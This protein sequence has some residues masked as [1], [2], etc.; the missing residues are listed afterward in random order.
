MRKL[1]LYTKAGGKGKRGTCEREQR[2][3]S[4]SSAEPSPDTHTKQLPPHPSA[5]NRR[6]SEEKD[7]FCKCDNIL[8]GGGQVVALILIQE[9][10]FYLK[11]RGK[12]NR[13]I[14]VPKKRPC[15]LA[16]LSLG[17]NTSHEFG[18]TS[19]ERCV[20]ISSGQKWNGNCIMM[21]E[22]KKKS[23]T[24]GAITVW[25]EQVYKQTHLE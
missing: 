10:Y 1:A 22:K 5:F 23:K 20:V 11:L 7:K 21:P 25:Q 8:A 14:L 19:Y 3:A 2:S 17:N 15:Y 4:Q 24:K 9:R 16:C 13:A 12:K 18:S 6:S